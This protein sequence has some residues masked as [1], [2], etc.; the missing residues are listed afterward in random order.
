M[1]KFYINIILPS[2]LSVF[3]FILAIFIV[4]I[5]RFQKNIMNDKRETIKELTNVAWSI[6]SK[7][8]RD[9]KDGLISREEAQKTAVSRIQYLRYGEENKDYF[10]IT[11]MG[12][13]MIIHPYRTDLTGKDLSDF[14]DP[15]GKKLFV[16][17][18]ETVKKSEQG[19]VDYMWQWKDDSLHIVPKLSYV[20]LFKPWNWVIG[21]G[22]YIEDVKKEIAALT[23]RLVWISTGITLL[24]AFLITYV[25][26]QSFT[27]DRKRIAAENKLH[28]SN[29]KYRTLVEAATEGLIML[30]EGKITYSNA[31]ISKMT[32]I[33]PAEL[34]N[35]Q[36]S[37]LISK[38]NN[39]DVLDIFSKNTIKEGQFELNL[40]QK[41]GGLINVLIV[42]SI[43]SFYGNTVNILIIKDISI[44]KN[45]PSGGLDYQ[46]LISTLNIGFFKARI[47]L[48]GKFLYANETAVRILGYD[49]FKELADVSI[50]RL[51]SETEDK[52]HIIR[53]LVENGFLKSRI[54]KIYKNDGS[55]SI[56]SLSLVVINNGKPNDLIC[57]GIIED[58]TLQENEIAQTNNL[59]AELKSTVFLMEQ[60]VSDYIIPF[61]PADADLSI[62]KSV[63]VMGKR[64]S[65]HLL[66]S[67]N[68]KDY[69]GIVTNSDIQKRVISL[70]LSPENP[71]YLIMSSPILYISDTATV[72]DAMIF[73]EERKIHHLVVRDEADTI[74]GIF[75]TE[76]IYKRITDSLLFFIHK[77][78]KSETHTELK[79]CYKSFQLLIKPLIKSD[80]SASYIT[81]LTSS[82]SDSVIRRIIELSI[83]E[84]GEPPV[85]FSFIC[86]GSE[87][88]K[89]ETLL[90]D[91]DNAIIYEDV[92]NE[93]ESSVG[94]YFMNLGERV[95]DSLNQV[96]Y[97]FCKGNIM[98]KNPQ[99]N[100]PVS[101]WKKYFSDWIMMPEPQNL[102]DATV[103][104][105]FRSVYGCPEFTDELRKTINSLIP[106][107]AVFLYH[108][109]HNAFSAKTQQISSVNTP[110]DKEGESIDL[111]SSINHIIMFARTYALQNSVSAVNTMERLHAL[112]LRQIIAKSMMDEMIYIYNFLMKLRFKNQIYLLEK[113]LPLTNHL[114][115]KSLNE[116]EIFTLKN[117][118]S[119]IPD[120]L[121]KI[122]I[123]FRL[124]I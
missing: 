54:L 67:K 94:E 112:E 62:G 78:N 80:I 117:I 92:F 61:T 121:N 107:H 40:V 76:E 105:D 21:T 65:S 55:Y 59:I 38:N 69:I 35:L 90:T 109:A 98:A 14:T 51:L 63:E 19:Y 24:I 46:K 32:G 68:S 82:F 106:N 122:K 41:N 53:S 93:N 97:S 119:K 10:W 96:G 103:F 124:T 26:K 71:L 17:F 22:I 12:P 33:Q 5:P 48:K 57:E 85:D 13:K 118:L 72:A 100:K 95:C 123:D 77:V 114:S 120:Y 89:E 88:R 29:E 47:D 27:I 83:I 7:Y 64:N 18:V 1:K 70:K 6:L 108:L 60:P 11:D 79:H 73:C 20:K 81:N 110:S 101:V 23:N 16:E 42:S 31:V 50:L 111:K 116:L 58:I 39:K 56:V 75:K 30:S 9:E 4:I 91:Q 8:E 74:K 25:L 102:L 44:D 37:D 104:F 52:K 43:T 34:L 49:N 36:L 3:L 87:G 66:V 99:W 115:T 15:H 113:N 84:I 28:E 86:L 45:V 2:I